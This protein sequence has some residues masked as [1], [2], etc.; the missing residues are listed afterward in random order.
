MHPTTAFAAPFGFVGWTIS[1]PALRGCLPFSLYTFLRVEAWLGITLSRDVG[2][3]EFG[4][5][6]PEDCSSSRP[7]QIVLSRYNAVMN[8]QPNCIVCGKRLRG[9][10]TRFCSIACKNDYHQGYESQKRRGIQRKLELVRAKGGHCSICGYH[11]NLSALAFHHLDSN[12][13]DFKLDM[14][15]LSNRKLEP[16]LKELDKCVLVCHN[17]HAELHNPHLDLDKLL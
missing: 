10:Q 8:N 5:L 1:S 4:R 13:K 16:T 7:A 17:C 12:T 2:F 15:S 11:K 3:P 14:R 6:A 9:R